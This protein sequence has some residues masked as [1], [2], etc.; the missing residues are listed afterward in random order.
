MIYVDFDDFNESNHRL[1]LLEKLHEKLPGFKVT[2]FTIPEPNTVG[3]LLKVADLDW[4]QMV[5]HGWRHSF[6]E[7]AGWSKERALT[8]LNMCDDLRVFKKGFKAPYWE[9]SNGLYEALLEK[10]YWIADHDRNDG[11]R[12]GDLPVYKV[13]VNSSHGHIQDVCG[14]GLEE[15]FDKLLKLQGPFGF[16]DDLMGGK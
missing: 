2:L 10:K 13:G 5:P 6:L 7:C 15:T 4:V 9:T 16:I 8:Y 3:F 1:D 11:I 14:N 12:P